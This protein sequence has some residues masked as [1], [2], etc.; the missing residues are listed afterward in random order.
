MRGHRR[1]GLALGALPL[2]GAVLLLAGSAQAYPQWQFSSGA[3]RCNQCHY[4]PAGGGLLTG[5]GRDANGEELSTWNGE[6]AF[7]HGA[8]EPPPWLT[9]GFDAR[10]A[11]LYHDAGDTDGGQPAVFPMQA[12]LGA[13]ASLPASLSLAV[14]VGARGQTRISGNQLGSDNY[15]PASAT[16]F[17]SQEHYLMWRPQAV[18]PYARAGRFFAPYGLRLAEHTVY[19]ERG[20]GLD[21]FEETYNLSGGWVAADWETHVTAFAP[22]FVRRMGGTESGGAAMYE[23]RWRDMLAAG[24][25]VRAGFKEGSQ[26][27]SGGGFGK[28]YLERAKTML[29]AEVDVLRTVVDIAPAETG[30]MSYGGF[31]V[32]PVRGLLLSLYGERDQ[33]SVK[34]ADSA[35]DAL[36]LQINWFPYPHFE[37]M[38]F[39]R[40]QRASGH[41][42]MKTALF[43]LHYFL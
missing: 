35:V 43:V 11:V 24:A 22:D 40:L 15:Q 33:T 6:G 28:L 32:F 3:G 1:P 10:G 20:V 31:T 5:F 27:Y 29:S 2:A 26:R 37:L 12:D 9:L 21:L 8:V 39:G 34:R 14:T 18:G 36:D 7:L 25:Q 41:E 23:R 30:V 19:A 13:R 42:P 16:R 17:I 38:A 4:A